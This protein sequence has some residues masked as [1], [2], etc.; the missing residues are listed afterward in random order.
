MYDSLVEKTHPDLAAGYDAAWE[1]EG[2]EYTFTGSAHG[3]EVA[4]V[5]AGRAN[6]LG[7]VGVAHAARITSL[8]VILSKSVA[9][10]WLEPA[11]A[12]A[13]RFDVVNMS[14]GGIVAFDPTIDPATWAPIAAHYASAA[15]TGRGGLGSVLVA[16][17][18]NNR[19]STTD[20]NLSWYQTN[21][22]TLIVGAANTAGMVSEYASPAPTCWWW[23]RPATGSAIPA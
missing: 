21:R 23:R 16:A 13:W 14:Y 11:M 2:L 18:G 9:L 8:P 12:Q 6:G 3:T 5:I 19:A 20:A 7:V 1:V 10:S 17:A 4:G 15:E 22:H